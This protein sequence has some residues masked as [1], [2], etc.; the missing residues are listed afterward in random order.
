MTMDRKIRMI[1]GT[2][3]LATLTPVGLTA[4]Q[5]E[6]AGRAQGDDSAVAGQRA[7]DGQLTA[8]LLSEL[9]WR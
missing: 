2:F 8:A 7:G 9:Q 5:L 3:V 1:V 4:G 6:G